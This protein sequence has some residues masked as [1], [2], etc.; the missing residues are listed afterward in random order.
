MRNDHQ[1]NVVIPPEK[2]HWSRLKKFFQAKFKGI[3][4]IS[5]DEI[6]WFENKVPIW[7]LPNNDPGYVP[8]ADI[9]V[10]TAWQTVEFAELLSADKGE[11]FYFGQHHDSLWSHNKIDDTEKIAENP[12]TGTTGEIRFTA[13]HIYVC[14]AT[15]T[16]KRTAISTF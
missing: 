12:A 16:W 9:L 7:V 11:K 4:T 15:N 13:D 8:S 6:D 2:I 10:A 1:V 5:P 14:V 3:Q